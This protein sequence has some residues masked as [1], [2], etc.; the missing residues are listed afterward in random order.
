MKEYTLKEICELVGVS[1]RAIQGY[2]QAKLVKASGKN[3]YGYLLYDEESVKKIKEVKMYQDF[4]FSINEIKILREASESDYQ[5]MLISKMEKIQK[6]IK[7]MED[8]LE[9]MKKIIEGSIE[10]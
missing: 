5:S 1:R 7:F 6:K 4:G 9:K 2:E 3:K 10:S 8:N